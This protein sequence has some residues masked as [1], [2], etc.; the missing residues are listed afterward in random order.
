MKSDEKRIMLRDDGKFPAP[1][2]ECKYNEKTAIFVFCFTH[3]NL[4]LST[5]TLA[6]Y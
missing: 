2:L 4:D 6:W 3:T 1:K 5:N